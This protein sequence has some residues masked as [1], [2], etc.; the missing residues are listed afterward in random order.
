MSQE[1]NLFLPLYLASIRLLLEHCVLFWFL[2][3]ALRDIDSLSAGVTHIVSPLKCVLI[4]HNSQPYN[5][6]ESWEH[7]E[8]SKMT[9]LIFSCCELY[10]ASQ[11]IA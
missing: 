7:F 6:N 8:R 9:V 4:C 3:L 1:S 11:A 2:C 10:T 5:I